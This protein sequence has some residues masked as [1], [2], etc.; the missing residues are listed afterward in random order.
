MEGIRANRLAISDPSLALDSSFNLTLGWHAGSSA[1]PRLQYFI[2]TVIRRIQEVT[3][4]S[5]LVFVGGSGGGFASLEMSRR[6]PGSVV[7]AMNP[8]TSIGK[9]LPFAVRRYLDLSWD[10]VAVLDEISKY[11]THD[12]VEG[13]PRVLNHTVA[14]V[15]NTRDTFHIENHQIPFFEKIGESPRVFM[16]MD[17][18]GD[19]EGTGHV[20]PPHSLVR[21][22]VRHL[23]AAN[24]GW[25]RT[26]VDLGFNHHTTA[27]T[28]ER[29]VKKSV[30]TFSSS[31]PS[32]PL[33]R[34][35]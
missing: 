35:E 26:L 11:S 28:V 25:K 24:G 3:G 2:E 6:F 5:N 13:Y 23:V 34:L 10:G 14:Y 17:A 20:V 27:V 1:Q 30:K 22:V 8:Q 4:I 19:P 16:L 33:A 29:A 31:P 7:V 18:W 32:S 12:L 9:Y 21:N 15:Q